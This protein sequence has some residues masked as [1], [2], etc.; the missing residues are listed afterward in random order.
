[1]QLF[2]RK[3][4]ANLR[5]TFVNTGY[6]FAGRGR[7]V[8]AGL[9]ETPALAR[10]MTS[11]L[12]AVT[13]E[14]GA[15][16]R[17]VSGSAGTMSGLRGTR[18]DDVAALIVSADATLGAVAV[19]RDDL[20]R[21][22]GELPPFEDAFL[23]TA[24]RAEPLLGDLEALSRDLRP[25]VR[26]LDATLPSVAR[27]LG[28]GETLRRETD[29]IADAAD[30]VLDRARPVAYGLFPTLTTLG[31]LN[32]DL[33]TLLTRVGPYRKEYRIPGRPGTIKGSGEIAEAGR[34]FI[35]ATNDP[36]ARGLAP[37]SPTWRVLPVLTPRPCQNPFPRPGTADKD[38]IV[39]GRCVKGG[40]R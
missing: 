37:G 25:T 38:T 34:R 7:E 31:P 39:Q 29:E 17:V 8:N 4:R 24:P 27:L 18:S 10:R 5:T 2:D 28:R 36:V 35:D 9:A 1:V 13:R 6:G 23:E 30:P 32:R 22:I 40:G 21:A 12:Q 3:T 33:K 11:Q 16:G 15:L 20:G 14:P 26:S 19:R